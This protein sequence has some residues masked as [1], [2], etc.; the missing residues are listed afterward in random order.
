[1]AQ[2]DVA[3]PFNREALR[4]LSGPL[5]EP[6]H[7][8]HLRERGFA[9]F[10]ATPMPSP[11]TE[12]W[13]YTDLR[14]FDLGLFEPVFERPAARSIDDV[15]PA[16]LD[17]AGDVG[18][19]SGLAVQHDSTMVAARL[20]GD[21]RE[22]GVTFASLEEAAVGHPDLLARYLHSAVGVDRSRFTAMHAAFRRGG[23][24]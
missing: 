15:A 17:S 22:R 4:R 13:R 16:I 21:L 1:M 2:A 3:S 18:A 7:L 19:R 23:A 10:E 20:E 8:R 6:A 24:I 5:D 12:E 14:E 9:T 11:E